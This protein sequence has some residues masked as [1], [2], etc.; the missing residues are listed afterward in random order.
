MVA[1]LASYGG[2]WFLEGTTACVTGYYQH[3]SIERIHLIQFEDVVFE[4][5]CECR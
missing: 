2:D 5:K 4:Q 1:W 3:D